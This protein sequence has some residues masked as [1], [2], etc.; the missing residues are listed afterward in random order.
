MP[1]L[2][3]IRFSAEDR[4]SA[5]QFI[6]ILKRSRLA[7]RRP[8]ED[9]E[10]ME[11]MVAGAGVI[12]TAWHGRLLV[13]VSRAISDFAYCTY[14]SELAV[15]ETYQ[16]LGIGRALVRRTRNAVKRR[17][18]LVLLAAPAAEGYYPHIGMSK[19]DSCWVLDGE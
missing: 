3:D 11:S 13:G 6:D 15:D 1:R 14:L 12:V 5:E 8:V 10:R 17:G 4:L 18:K 9:A 2:G 16:G 19:H 7:E